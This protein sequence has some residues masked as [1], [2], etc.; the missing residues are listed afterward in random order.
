MN[1]KTK[2]QKCIHNYIFFSID[3][4]HGHTAQMQSSERIN[5][6]IQEKIASTSVKNDDTLTEIVFVDGS[7]CNFT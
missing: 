5:S 3:I 7:K 1:V 6:L 4:L 2:E